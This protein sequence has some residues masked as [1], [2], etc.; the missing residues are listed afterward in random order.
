MRYPD[1]NGIILYKPGKTGIM[2]PTVE[3][4]LI[5]VSNQLLSGVILQT[6]TSWAE[7]W[8]VDEGGMW[9]I[10]NLYTLYKMQQH[11]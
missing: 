1:I 3:D 9:A 7:E 11:S 4:L 6:S 5:G 2:N 8:L 10:G